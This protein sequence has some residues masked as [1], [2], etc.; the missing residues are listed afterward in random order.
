MAGGIILIAALDPAP[1]GTLL[2]IVGLLALL[3]GACELVLRAIRRR[4]TRALIRARLFDDDIGAPEGPARSVWP[5][6]EPEV[7]DLRRRALL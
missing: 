5:R 3:A 6:S 7:E 2:A 4:Q 1:G